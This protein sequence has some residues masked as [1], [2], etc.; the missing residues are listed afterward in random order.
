M[1][2]DLL[3]SEEFKKLELE[4]KFLSRARNKVNEL[5]DASYIFFD[6]ETTG[7]EPEKAE[8]IEIAA[9]KV[10]K[11]EIVKIFNTLIK[12]IYPIP[13][14][15]TRINGIDNNMVMGHPKFDEAYKQ[16]LEM[17]ED[18]CILVAHNAEFD[19]GFLNCHSKQKLKNDI[20]CSLKASRFALPNLGSHKLSSVAKYFGIPS[21]N[22]HR[23]LA[24]V[25][26]LYQ[27]W[28]KLLDKLRAKQII[29]RDDLRK[30]PG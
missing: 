25:E 30:I 4:Y 9:I 2:S 10:K 23:A 14:N 7:L 16:F 6:T 13:S 1:I 26:M 22:A 29:T 20:V 19:I 27:I 15:I 11:K 18:D 17:V 21:E 5:E 8:I 24:D 3:S 12:P 28:F